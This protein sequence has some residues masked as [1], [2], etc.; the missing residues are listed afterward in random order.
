[1]IDSSSSHLVP[2]QIR[3]L[4]IEIPTVRKS[5]A[6]SFLTTSPVEPS[7]WRIRPPWTQPQIDFPAAAPLESAMSNFNKTLRLLK[8]STLG[9]LIASLSSCQPLGGED[10]LDREAFSTESAP[11]VPVNNF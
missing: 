4:S 6:I 9:L 5:V 1:M 8:I 10:P 2:D 11:V 7:R 3:F